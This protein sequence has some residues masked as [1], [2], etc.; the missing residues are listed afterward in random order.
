MIRG[1]LLNFVH[2]EWTDNNKVECVV[3]LDYLLWHLF[4]FAILLAIN[5]WLVDWF[6]HWLTDVTDWLT[7]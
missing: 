7:D 1:L 5:V 6:V 3:C 2:L 4:Y